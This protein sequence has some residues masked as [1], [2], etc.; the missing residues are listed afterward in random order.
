MEE[1]TMFV[2]TYRDIVSPV[3]MSTDGEGDDT[4]GNT[5]FIGLIFSIL[6]IAGID[7]LLA[8]ISAPYYKCITFNNITSH[9]SI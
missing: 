7:W 1:K 9:I 6:F 2:E 3:L 8:V 5:W 4:S